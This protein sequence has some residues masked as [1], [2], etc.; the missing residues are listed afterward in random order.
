MRENSF[1]GNIIALEGI[2][3]SGTTTQARM[4]CESEQ[5][6]YTA[7]HGERREE[8]SLIG[9]KVEDMISSEG[10]S[11]QAT[12]LAFSAD[13]MVH[14]EEKVIPLL[15]Q[16]KNVVFDR[17]YHSSLVYQP[18]SGADFSWVKSINS[19]VLRPDFTFV[20]DVS[21]EVGMNR[22]E[23]RGKDENVFENM[24]IQ[25]EA[26]LR[27]RQLGERLDERIEIVDGT[28]TKQEVQNKILRSLDGFA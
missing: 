17:Y 21:A 25:K 13:R 23:D 14:L 5:Y 28:Q 16:G 27:Y 3:G 11:P 7:E 22:I 4:L 2:D 1:S 12:A 20:L 18:A 9:R 26:S 19:M 15:K 24:S 6:V 8:D 10:Y